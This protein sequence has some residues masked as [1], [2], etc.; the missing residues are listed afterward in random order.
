LRRAG[1]DEATLDG[2]LVQLRQHQLVDDRAFA[3]Y[4]VEQRQTFR[5]RGARLLRAELA[6]LGVDRGPVD[7]AVGSVDGSAEADAYRAALRQ[8]NRLHGLDQRSFATRLSQWL[9]RRGFDWDTISPVVARL[10]AETES[11]Q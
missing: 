10:W 1:I 7:A 6:R 4:W 3:D 2:V 9:A 11:R 5:P 8:A